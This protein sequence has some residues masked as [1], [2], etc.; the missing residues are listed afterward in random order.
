MEN[1]EKFSAMVDNL[2]EIR[3]AVKRPQQIK[4]R[5]R[6]RIEYAE[7]LKKESEERLKNTLEKLEKIQ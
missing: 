3:R 5:A 1:F 2:L 7:R 4:E 6:K